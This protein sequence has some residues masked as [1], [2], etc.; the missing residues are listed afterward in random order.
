L[1]QT[2]FFDQKK[3]YKSL[4]KYKNLLIIVGNNS[5]KKN[6]LFISLNEI[7]PKE[8]LII[9]SVSDFLPKYVTAL[10]IAKKINQKK[11]LSILAIGGGT[12]IDIS[13]LT[14]YLVLT[15]S[16]DFSS[17]LNAN[18]LIK[19]NN[20]LKLFVVPTTAGSGAESTN[21]CVSYYK[22]KK[23]SIQSKLIIPNYVYFNPKFIIS[24]NKL[25]TLSSG[26]DI[27]AQS[28]ES[29]WSVNS[30]IESANYAFKSLELLLNNFENFCIKP[31]NKYAIN[32]LLAAN[33]AGKAINI[34]KT[35]APHAFSYYLTSVHKIP[36]GLAVSLLI[37][38]FYKDIMSNIYNIKSKFIKKNIIKL[39][40][41]LTKY[42]CNAD[43]FE[44][45][46]NKI[47]IKNYLS[48]LTIIKVNQ[49]NYFKSINLQRLNNYPL[50]INDDKILEII[51]KT[52]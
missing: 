9:Y 50:K 46:Y 48:K 11:I 8:N 4:L 19:N 1:K 52:F 47:G 26:L 41:I 31:D 12:I 43:F 34:S 33:F 38:Y 2:F 45:F 17:L 3:F 6:K 23:Y 10:E 14:R 27:L 5:Y 25:N 44:Y 24:N 39:N 21:F 49:E 32:M 29:I 15:K 20:L 18:N 35:T 37:P 7:Y 30:N 51:K 13:K 28:I 36:H 42:S 16:N 40:S 22:K